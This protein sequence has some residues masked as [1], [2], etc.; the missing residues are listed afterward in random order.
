VVNLAAGT[1]KAWRIKLPQVK[2]G[3]LE[4][5]GVEAFVLEG[6][7]ANDALLGMSFLNRVRWKEDQGLMVLESKF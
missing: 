2:V 6:E 7:G 5:L 3:P 4:V 1:A